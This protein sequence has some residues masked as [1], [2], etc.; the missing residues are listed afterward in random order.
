M[1]RRGMMGP[2][3]SR[4]RSSLSNSGRKQQNQHELSAAVGFPLSRAAL[5]ASPASYLPENGGM[6]RR[7]LHSSDLSRQAHVSEDRDRDGQETVDGDGKSSEPSRTLAL[8]HHAGVAS[9]STALDV[10]EIEALA[11]S[12]PHDQKI[13]TPLPAWFAPSKPSIH[14][15]PIIRRPG[16]IVDLKTLLRNV[17]SMPPMGFQSVLEVPVWKFDCW[18]GDTE[19][20]LG[21]VV[22]PSEIFNV[23]LRTH[24]VHSAYWFH[25]YAMAGWTE[26]MQL[27]K[28]E[29]PGSH[30]KFRTQKNSGRSR[31]GW[32]KAPGKYL[33]VFSKPFRPHDQRIK[34]F[35]RKLYLALKVM[36]TAKFAQAQIIVVDNFNLRSHKT[37]YAVQNFR[38]LVG[39]RCNS[40]LCI[41]EGRGDVNNNFRWAVANLT[42]VRRENV[43]A[44]SSFNVLRCKQLMITEKALQKLIFNIQQYP[45]GRGWAIKYATPDGKRAPRPKKVPGW[46]QQWR[47][48]KE[49]EE[50]ARF[51]R[52][53][54][55]ERK[56]KWRW[57]NDLKGP[58]K[59]QRNDPLAGFRVSDFSRSSTLYPWD[60]T[61]ELVVDEEPLDPEEDPRGSEEVRAALDEREAVDDGRFDLIGDGGPSGLSLWGSASGRR[62]GKLGRKDEGVGA[63]TGSG[64]GRNEGG[65]E[66]D[67]LD[68][69]V[70]SGSG[71]EGEEEEDD[72]G[73]GGG[74]GDVL[75]SREGVVRLGGGARSSSSSFLPTGW[76]EGESEGDGDRGG[77][78]RAGGRRRWGGDSEAEIL[79]DDKLPPIDP[80]PF[81][82]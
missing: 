25:R 38:R 10:S 63:P 51:D 11:S 35:K 43:E 12:L 80:L 68:S 17:S 47:E 30:S 55:R 69:D 50:K 74:W 60:R 32:K 56:M 40:C 52:R 49:R 36:L 79:E 44:V 58:M 33:G 8:S 31:M 61:E 76:M 16:E 2:C 3:F 29:W 6:Q 45:K 4:V 27:S 67:D 37:K 21:T 53:L 82:R 9:L 34:I 7:A 78:R 62:A 75:G 70:D 14:D 19:G 77:E 39:H 71:S 65:D 23:P 72:A 64:S 73:G 24:L 42:A 81:G 5:P 18:E 22:L 15:P 26:R 1:M 66:D 20:E 59:I 48:Q 13:E 46:D 28:W 57:S 41:H 54:L